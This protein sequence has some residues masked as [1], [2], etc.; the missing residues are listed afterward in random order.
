MVDDKGRPV[1]MRMALTAADKLLKWGVGLPMKQTEVQVKP[2][3]IMRPRFPPGTD[4]D[5]IRREL[6]GLDADEVPDPR[7]SRGSQTCAENLQLKS[8]PSARSA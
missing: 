1:G 5:V 7:A 8:G 6:L 3:F 4:P 2:N